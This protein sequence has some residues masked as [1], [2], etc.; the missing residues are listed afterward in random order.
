MGIRKNVKARASSNKKLKP[1]RKVDYTILSNRHELF[2]H[3]P[4]YRNV[5]QFGDNKT[6]D[7]EWLIYFSNPQYLNFVH[8][9]QV[10]LPNLALRKSE[11]NDYI[12]AK[13][14]L[15][16]YPNVNVYNMDHRKYA[17][18]VDLV[19]TVVV[20]G[21]IETYLDVWF[22]K[23]KSKGFLVFSRLNTKISSVQDAYTELDRLLNLSH[24]EGHY[25]LRYLT[26]EKNPAVAIQRP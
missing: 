14:K 24:Q 4:S 21:N 5:V 25:I 20:S 2:K 11:Q 16:K 26:F 10:T 18:I 7:V 22:K 19:D 15:A 23:L 3:L 1:E 6:E 12:V 8:K 17:T 9:W 13:S